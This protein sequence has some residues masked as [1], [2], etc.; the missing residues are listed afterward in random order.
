M[1]RGENVPIK[2]GMQEC[3][4]SLLQVHHGRRTLEQTRDA[5]FEVKPRTILVVVIHERCAPALGLVIAD[6]GEMFGLHLDLDRDHRG[7]PTACFCGRVGVG[8]EEMS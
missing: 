3:S 6:L 4:I 8:A 5:N 7:H 2:L 1:L